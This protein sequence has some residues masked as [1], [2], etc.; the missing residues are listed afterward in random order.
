M[1]WDECDLC[2]NEQQKHTVVVERDGKNMD[3]YLCEDCFKRNPL[4]EDWLKEK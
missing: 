2:E 4:P 3:L 1:T